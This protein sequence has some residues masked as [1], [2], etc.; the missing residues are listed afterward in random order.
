MAQLM[1]VQRSPSDG[2]PAADRTG[3]AEL[4]PSQLGQARR[5]DRPSVREMD[6]LTLPEFD[7]IPQ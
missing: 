7:S 2:D 5:P 6:V 4:Q 3:A 1:R